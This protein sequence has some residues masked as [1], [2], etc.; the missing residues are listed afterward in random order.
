MAQD[1]SVRGVAIGFN[2]AVGWSHTVSNSKRTVMYQLTLSPDD[3]SQYRFEDGGVRVT[4]VGITIKLLTRSIKPIPF[5]FSHR[6]PLM[7]LPVSTMIPTVFAVRDANAENIHTF[8]QWQAMG[9]AQSMDVSSMLTA[10]TTQ[11]LGEHHCGLC[12][13]S[14]GVHR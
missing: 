5:W 13:W 3:P 11:C 9:S 14:C 8:A 7:A 10:N 4:D 2:E 1:S 12:R 6:N